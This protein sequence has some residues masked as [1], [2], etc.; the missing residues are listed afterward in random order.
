MGS[1]C[2]GQD[3]YWIEIQ[4]GF[5]ISLLAD[6]RSFQQEKHSTKAPVMRQNTDMIMT[7]S[8][9]NDPNE[10]ALDDDDGSMEIQQQVIEW[11]RCRLDSETFARL[12]G[13]DR[14]S[15]NTSENNRRSNNSTIDDDDDEDEQIA[16]RLLGHWI[17]QQYCPP[18]SFL[19]AIHQSIHDR[20]QQASHDPWTS[21]DNIT[22]NDNTS[23]ALLEC[24]MAHVG[25][26]VAKFFEDTKT[27]GQYFLGTVTRYDAD[28]QWW[29]IAYD[30]GDYEDM[31]ADELWVQLK[32]YALNGRHLESDDHDKKTD[33]T[34][35]SKRQK[36]AQ[37][38]PS[39][40]ACWV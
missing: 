40:A 25:R 5:W 36:K 1:L 20:R 35:K 16:Q 11:I 39:S 30:D 29:R 12:C 21:N 2:V 26:R 14:S 6:R 28:E 17:V 4:V 33:T 7:L 24:P 10:E 32:E 18:P 34:K 22:H 27:P 3:H 37:T 19:Q 9:L 13:N 15:R 31:S 38:D 23:D 8:L